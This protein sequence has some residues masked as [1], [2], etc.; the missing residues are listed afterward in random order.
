MQPTNFMATIEQLQFKRIS[1]NFLE[2][3]TNNK[4]FKD[5][6]QLAH[7]G[8]MDLLMHKHS[9]VYQIDVSNFYKSHS[10]ELNIFLR[11]P[12]VKRN[13]LLKLL[14]IINFHNFTQ[15]LGLNLTMR[16]FI[17]QDLLANRAVVA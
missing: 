12:I 7:Q 14:Q 15:N 1:P 9:D 4:Q 13:K 17:D 10:Q 6:Q 8:K 16:P 11:A 2:G 5:L 3:S